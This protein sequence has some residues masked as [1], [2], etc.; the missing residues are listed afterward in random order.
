[1]T[2]RCLLTSF[3]NSPISTVKLSKFSSDTT[4]IHFPRTTF[5][6]GTVASHLVARPFSRG[7]G[8]FSQLHEGS[9]GP[10]HQVLR[11]AW[12]AAAVAE[13]QG[14]QPEGPGRK[15]NM[16]PETMCFMMF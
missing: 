15:L 6:F 5:F 14:G 4:Y 16:A 9:V 3:K 8:G 1:M 12:A 10:G 7:F 11:A 13:G 2:K